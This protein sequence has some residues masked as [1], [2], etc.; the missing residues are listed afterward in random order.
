MLPAAQLGSVSHSLVRAGMGRGNAAGAES[1]V[2]VVA[3]APLLWQNWAKQRVVDNG[4][5]QV[6]VHLLFRS[7]M[8]PSKSWTTCSRLRYQAW[9]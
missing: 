3:G 7:W 9:W 2:E 6:I 5:R 8:T 1:D 4:S